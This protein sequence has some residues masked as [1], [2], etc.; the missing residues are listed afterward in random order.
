MK[1]IFILAFTLT[2]ITGGLKAQV[3]FSAGPGLG[4]NYAFHSSSEADETINH[5]G[6]LVTSQFDMQ[7]SRY[8]GLLIWVDFYSDMSVNE[9]MDYM[10]YTYKIKYLH[11]S[12][13]LKFCVPRSPLYLFAGP[14]IAFKTKG[15]IEAS[16]ENINASENITGMKTRFDFRFGVGYDFF[17][18]NKI[19]LS[20]FVGFNTGLNDVTTGSDWKINTLQAGLIVRYNA[21]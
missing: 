5:F 4:F 10:D 11:L 12:P 20:P 7:F 16:Y 15:K 19:T 18:T 21:F 6:A 17:I 2:T 8:I 14:G 3:Q 13:T 1:Q 9:Q